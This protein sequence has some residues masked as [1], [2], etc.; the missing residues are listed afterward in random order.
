[1][2]PLEKEVFPM[3][4][5]RI[6]SAFLA[7]S[8]LLLLFTGCAKTPDRTEESEP[9]EGPGLDD[10]KA[11]DSLVIYTYT[12]ADVLDQRRINQFI[13]IYGVDVEVVRVDGK[14]PE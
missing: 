13:A 12:G 2:I 9:V 6:L 14:I 7:V 4:S 3:K 1:M 10:L 8:L 11:T 5:R